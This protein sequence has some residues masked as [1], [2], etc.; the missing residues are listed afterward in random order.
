MF[1]LIV[2]AK[3]PAWIVQLGVIKSWQS[4]N[5]N[6]LLSDLTHCRNYSGQCNILFG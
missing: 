4:D 2:R 5:N 6:Y 3:G 1:R